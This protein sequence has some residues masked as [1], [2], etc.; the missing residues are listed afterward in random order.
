MTEQKMFLKLL[1]HKKLIKLKKKGV[2]S[3]QNAVLAIVSILFWIKDSNC[4]PE[5]ST[6]ILLKG[7]EITDRNKIFF[8]GYYI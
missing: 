5:G 8:L 3:K 2:K 6:R 1:Y 7:A 4:S